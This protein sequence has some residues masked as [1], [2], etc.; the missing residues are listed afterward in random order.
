MEIG[1]VVFVVLSFLG[2]FGLALLI[3]FYQA[4]KL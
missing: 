3:G 1:E 2:C 4:G